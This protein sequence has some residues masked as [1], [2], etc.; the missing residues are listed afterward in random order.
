[1]AAESADAGSDDPAVRRPR[2]KLLLFGV[3]LAV[4]ATLIYLAVSNSPIGSQEEFEELLDD[5]GWWAPVVYVLSMAV[6]QPL[7]VPGLLFMVPAALVWDAPYAI[8]YSW[9]GNMTA[10]CIAFVFARR[11]GRERLRPRIPERILRY[12]QRIADREYLSVTALRVLTGQ[13]VAADWFLGLSTVRV[14]PFLV[15]T[16]LGIIPGILLAVFV[17]SGIVELFIER[18]L[19]TLGLTA[20]G[21]IGWRLLKRRR[22]Q[23]GQEQ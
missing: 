11:Y 13:L 10:S 20:V 4:A 18:P 19:L 16:G 17:G 9:I 5:L 8:A 7:G 15:G 6:F 23:A 21:V 3:V 12:E 14:A 2:W 1:V 22:A